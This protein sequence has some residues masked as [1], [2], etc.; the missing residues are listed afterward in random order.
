MPLV[1]DLEEAVVLVSFSS[2]KMGT[3]RESEGEGVQLK[4]GQA[5]AKTSQENFAER[6]KFESEVCLSF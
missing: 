2:C 6:G 1:F 3:G 4:P 5:A